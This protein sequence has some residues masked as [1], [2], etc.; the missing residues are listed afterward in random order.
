MILIFPLHIVEESSGLETKYIFR[1]R[2]QS[3]TPLHIGSKYYTFT[4]LLLIETLVT[5]HFAGINC[6]IT[7]HTVTTLALIYTKGI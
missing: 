3:T 2:E 5:S 1:M 4:P 6:N 7:K